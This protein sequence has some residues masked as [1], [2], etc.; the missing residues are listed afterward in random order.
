MLMVHQNS[1]ITWKLFLTE[2]NLDYEIYIP[3]RK[4]G[5]GPICYKSLKN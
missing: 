2:L 1:F 5:Y 3:D 4:E